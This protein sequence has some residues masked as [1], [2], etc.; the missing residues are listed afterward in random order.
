MN[1]IKKNIWAFGL[2]VFL[3]IG[4]TLAIKE[5]TADQDGYDLELDIIDAFYGDFDQDRI[6]DDIRV[7]AI[8]DAD[9]N[10]EIFS[11]LTLDIELPSGKVFHF[12]FQV[13]FYSS[14]DSVNIIT[15]TTYNTATESGWYIATVSGYFLIDG[16][17]YYLMDSMIFDPPESDGEGDPSGIVEIKSSG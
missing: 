10:G 13:S 6:E 11:L 16:Y 9:F 4:S 5:A 3:I 8:L 17:F 1:R 2:L 12:T 7:I 14:E 15:F